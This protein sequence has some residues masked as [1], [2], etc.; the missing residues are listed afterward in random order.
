MILEM[1]LSYHVP[2][3]VLGAKKKTVTTI[4]WAPDKL[5]SVM[6]EEL[7]GNLLSRV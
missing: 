1:N 3:I 4:D 2:G 5:S 7:T 6:T